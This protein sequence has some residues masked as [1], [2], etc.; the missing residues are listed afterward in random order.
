VVD[1]GVAGVMS[2][3]N[4]VNGE[5][6]GQNR[7]LL[8]SI[9]KERWGFD[10][11]VVSDWVFG[12][13]DGVAAVNAGLDLEMPARIFIDDRVAAAVERGLVPQA[14][15]DDA[16]LRLIR[17]QLR[18]AEAGDGEYEDDVIACD[19]H[20]ALAREVAAKSIVLLRNEAVPNSA[21]PTDV[22]AGAAT[23]A[24]AGAAAGTLVRPV[25]PLDPQSLRSVAVIGRLAD[26]PNTGDHGSSKV[27]APYI[28][29][30]LEGIRSALEP[31]GV[32][33][34]HDDASKP[35][36]AA[37]VAVGADA[38]IVVA[39]YDFRAEGEYM[40]RFPPPGFEKLLP[41]P[42][43]RLIP[44]AL[45]TAARLRLS[46]S[47]AFRGGGDRRSLTSM[48][49]RKR[50]SRRSRPPTAAQSSCWSAVRQS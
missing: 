32:K 15:V 19:G 24:T 35:Q 38:V 29:T 47:G 3:Y 42:P 23:G 2:A 10:G 34:V 28:V 13:R 9:L 21:R 1:E 20:R 5:W 46:D 11:F 7:R 49:M 12:I 44:R 6:C 30:P 41:H 16:A 4:A 14:R 8:T 45:V 33:V 18:F 26:V 40:G 48:T 22:A 39:G 43:L 31:L 27:T 50:S 37:T 36:R 17:Q 25:L